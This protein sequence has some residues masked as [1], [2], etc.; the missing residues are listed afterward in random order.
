MGN[1]ILPQKVVIQLVDGFGEPI[2]ISDV[3][4]TV[5]LFARHK[6]DIYLAPFIS[7]NFGMI[8]ITR[9]DLD[10]EIEKI[11][12]SMDYYPVKTCFPFIE[13][14]VNQPE[15]IAR[16]LN[17]R[18]KYWP[19]LLDEEKHRWN[20]IDD[21]LNGYRQARNKELN[22]LKGISRIRDEWDGTQRKYMYNLAV[23]K[24][25]DLAL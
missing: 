6:N 5:H 17:E 24:K 13:I 10:S 18:E 11:S 22:I 7:D 4:V 19:V 15:D 8:M 12:G 20:S 9:K 1:I 21:L 23:Y 16:L 14:F 2:N 3:I 25:E